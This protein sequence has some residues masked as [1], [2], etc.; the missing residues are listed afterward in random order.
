MALMEMR[1]VVATLVQKFD[2]KFAEGYDTRK[3]AD[4]L[5]DYFSTTVGE[6]P[7]VLHARFQK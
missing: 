6:L 2:M 7:V 3:W 4:D 5:K 1:M